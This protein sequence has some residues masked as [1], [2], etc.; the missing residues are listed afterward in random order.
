M[1]GVRS[2]LKRIAQII[3][4]VVVFPSACLAMFGR[5]HEGF[6]FFA[7]WWALAPGMAGS[8]LRVAYYSLTLERCGADC[9][10]AFGSYFSHSQA[11]IGDRVGIG[12]Y[13]ILGRVTI[14]DGTMVASGCQ[15]LSGARQHVRDSSGELSDEGGDFRRV[16]IG[17]KCWIGAG[18]IVMADLGSD[19]TVAVG[20]V[21]SRDV[22]NG[23]TMAGNPARVVRPAVAAVSA[24]S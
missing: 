9:H 2:G 21:I 5:F 1:G 17:A 10:I 23:S 12:A 6:I 4:T 8:Y 20:T 3:A 19:V 14:G 24:V 13:C 18:S 15:V 22:P 16:T 11:A 7:Q